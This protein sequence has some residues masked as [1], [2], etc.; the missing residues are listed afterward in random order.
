MGTPTY[1]ARCSSCTLAY[2]EDEKCSPLSMPTTE[3]IIEDTNAV[4]S[5]SL[6]YMHFKSCGPMW[7]DMLVGVLV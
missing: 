7:L 4:K 1:H 2:R 5:V 6:M 3:R